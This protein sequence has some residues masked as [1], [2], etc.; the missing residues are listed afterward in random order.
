M[1]GERMAAEAAEAGAAFARAAAL[2]VPGFG[3]ESWFGSDP[4]PRAV[5]TLARGSSDAAAT[6]LAY[7]I[8]REARLPATSL[9]PSVFSLGP[10]LALGG[11]LVLVVS[12]SG[13]SPDLVLAARGARA[14]GARVVAITNT[15]GAPVE[16][17]ADLVLPAGAGPERAVPAT[18]SVAAS[19]GAGLALL[20]ALAPGYAPRLAAAAAALGGLGP[21]APDPALATLLARGGSVYV[22]GRDCGLGAAQELALKL[23]EC[24]ALHAEAHSASEVLHGPLRLAPEGLTAL[25]LETGPAAAAPSLDLAA[26]RL[27]EHGAAVRRLGPPAGLAP[28]PPAAAAVAILCRLYPVVRAAALARG[29]DPDAPDTLEKVTRTR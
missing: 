28:L 24:C 13:A 15:P 5:L 6:V 22:I 14:G 12:Q 10:G 16:A 9:P 23:K 19:V 17:E 8:M 2:A 11:A 26:A 3:P 25:V 21:V 7:E 4:T 1:A 27:A 29:L 20:A 18:K